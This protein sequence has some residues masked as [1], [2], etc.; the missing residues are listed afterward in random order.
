MS[1]KNSLTTLAPSVVVGLVV[2]PLTIASPPALELS[3]IYIIKVK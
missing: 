2:A 1:E 3:I